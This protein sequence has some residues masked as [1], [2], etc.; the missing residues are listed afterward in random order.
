MTFEKKMNAMCAAHCANDKPCLGLN[1]FVFVSSIIAWAVMLLSGVWVLFIPLAAV[2]QRAVLKSES[3]S[4]RTKS[5]VRS[6][7]YAICFLVFCG[8]ATALCSWLWP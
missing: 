1:V 6:G 2:I 3:R 7:I 8:F 4:G 5:A